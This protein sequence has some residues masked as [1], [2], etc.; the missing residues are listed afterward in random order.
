[1]NNIANNI[2]NASGEL[3]RKIKK[4]ERDKYLAQNEN[5][6][7][8]YVTGELIGFFFCFLRIPAL[9]IRLLITKRLINIY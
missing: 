3:G 2:S 4:K 7:R 8:Y 9:D 5:W 1:M 6:T